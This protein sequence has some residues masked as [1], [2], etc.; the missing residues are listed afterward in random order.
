MLALRLLLERHEDVVGLGV[1]DVSTVDDLLSALYQARG[2][3]YAVVQIVE[4]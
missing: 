4:A 2:Q 1:D 3:R